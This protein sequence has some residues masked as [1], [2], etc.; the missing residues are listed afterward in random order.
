VGSCLVAAELVS[1][2]TPMTKTAMT[3][4]P[5]NYPV[6][7]MENLAV[8]FPDKD[9]QIPGRLARRGLREIT[10]DYIPEPPP[11]PR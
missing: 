4:I 11:H 6:R 2:M 7:E 9:G 3:M 8:Y 10:V 5:K 1:R